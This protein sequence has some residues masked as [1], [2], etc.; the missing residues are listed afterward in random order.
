MLVGNT[1]NAE[2]LSAQQLNLIYSCNVNDRTWHQVDPANASTDNIVPIVPQLGSGTRSSFLAAI[3][4]PSLGT[5]V[6][7]SEEN[8]PTA[9]AAQG[10]N[11]PDAIE[12]MSG[13]RRHHCAARAPH[14]DRYPVR[15]Q[16]AV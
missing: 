9:I 1:T 4:N 7:T 16:P 12:P 10:A 14:Y 8:D 6:V 2:A 13:G 15:Q 3:G 5:C 11:A